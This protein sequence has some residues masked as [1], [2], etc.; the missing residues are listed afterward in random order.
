VTPY[1]VV[2]ETGPGGTVIVGCGS[3]VSPQQPRVPINGHYVRGACD[4]RRTRH[5]EFGAGAIVG[6]LLIGGGL[7]AWQRR[8]HRAAGQLRPTLPLNLAR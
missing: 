1:F 2:P 5:E 3:V 7:F 6:A 8:A 4:E